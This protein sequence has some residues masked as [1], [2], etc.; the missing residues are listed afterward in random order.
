M[1]KLS[2][3]SNKKYYKFNKNK[4]Y[5]FDYAIDILKK[6]TIS[7]FLESVDVS[8]NL[9]IDKNKTKNN[10]NNF[11]I[12]PYN[13]KKKLKIV[14]FAQG[15]NADLAKKCG[16]DFVGMEDLLE[17]IKKDE[18]KYDVV[19]ATP[20]SVKLI[21]S[22]GPI[23][24]PKGLMPNSKLDTITNNIKSSIKNIKNGK[25]Q[26]KSDKNGII[27]TTIG[28]IN[29][30]NYELKENLKFLLSDI[31]KLKYNKNKGNFL[32][33]VYLSTTMGIAINL[34]ISNII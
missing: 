7:S 34:I 23:L 18:I 22:L 15:K 17:L 9:N 24:G 10:I 27:N 19:I 13:I 21:K 5:K 16:A 28:K 4:T 1:N 20:D 30:K 29:F 12:L 33:K 2:K 6:N 8:I 32:K 26:Y 11:I 3:K 31:Q 14:V 25:I